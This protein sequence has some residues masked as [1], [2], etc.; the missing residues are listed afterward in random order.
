LGLYFGNGQKKTV[1]L[2]FKDVAPLSVALRSCGA[3]KWRL[4]HRFGYFRFV[5]KKLVPFTVEM[6]FKIDFEL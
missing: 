1:L 3:T 6:A 5:L 4:R 2:I